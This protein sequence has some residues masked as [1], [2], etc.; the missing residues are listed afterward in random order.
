MNLNHIN[1]S[2]M[3][4][5]NFEI[6]ENYRNEE[7]LRNSF[8][9]LADRIFG[10]DFEKWHSLGFWDESY[11]CHSI[12]D[13]SRGCDQREI[14]ANVSTTSMNLEINNR[15]LKALQIGTVMTHPDFRGR[16][17][18]DRLMKQVLDRYSDQVDIFFLFANPAA[19]S[20]YPRH[21]FV[22]VSRNRFFVKFPKEADRGPAIDSEKAFTGPGRFLN[23]NDKDDLE[24][25]KKIVAD[26][27]PAAGKLRVC[28]ANAIQLWHCVN[29]YPGRLHYYSDRETILIHCG[30]EES[31]EQINLMDVI[32]KSVHLPSVLQTLIKHYS[33]GAMGKP[34]KVRIHFTPNMEELKS[35]GWNTLTE[36][37]DPELFVKYTTPACNAEMLPENAELFPAGLAF[38]ATATA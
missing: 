38:P 15:Q 10:I 11:V 36:T 8:N 13:S 26:H 34:E 33:D 24:I 5:D 30:D 23:L 18:A 9:A 4:S 27:V 1:P 17:F 35:W 6:V 19:A 22:P 7:T 28:G 20:F 31:P 21:G 14:V 37:D 32:G 12:L 2:Q 29:I 16:G 25:L 3:N